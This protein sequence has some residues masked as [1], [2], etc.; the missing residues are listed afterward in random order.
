MKHRTRRLVSVLL[1]LAV[2]LLPTGA[3][4]SEL[5]TGRATTRGVANSNVVIYDIEVEG[6]VAP[7]DG[8]MPDTS[9]I[10][11]PENANYTIESVWWFNDNAE[12]TSAFQGGQEYDV[13]IYITAKQGY[14]FIDEEM[15]NASINGENVAID[16]YDSAR[17]GVLISYNFPKVP[18]TNI[19]VE[20]LEAPVPGAMPDT[21]AIIDEQAGYQIS[22]AHGISWYKHG[23]YANEVT[24][25]FKAGEFYDAIIWLAPKEGNSFAFENILQQYGNYQVNGK[26]ASLHR[27]WGSDLINIRCEFSKLDISE[28][29][30]SGIVAPEVGAMP[31]TTTFTIPNN[32]SYNIENIWWFD[33]DREQT[34]AFEANKSYEVRLFVTPKPGASFAAEDSMQ[35]S[36]N[37]N[38]VGIARYDGAEYSVL[39]A[40]KFP[41]LAS[42]QPDEENGF[43]DIF[44]TD[45]YYQPVQWAVDNKITSG[46]DP[47]HFSP[48]KP[49][50][51]AD[52]LTFLWRSMGEPEPRNVHNPFADVS[53]NAYYYKAVLWAVENNISSGISSTQFGPMQVCDRGQIVTFLWRAQ[54]KP[55]V[56]L[57]N[58]FGDVSSNQYY[59]KAVQWAVNNNIT[60]GTGAN[61]FSPAASCTRGQIV[62]FLYNA[63]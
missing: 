21:T 28:I 59:A 46:V 40:Y 58:S 5:A 56:A 16:R 7:A 15:L 49:C 31:D 47:H 26:D 3:F 44:V 60:K 48:N 6:V 61:K 63:K 14:T 55:D 10:R 42:T 38:D 45:Y 9:T 17:D 53:P 25:P 52:A 51:R 50:R 34:S 36:I 20:G 32:A 62:T 2:G 43:K 1:I 37:G 27:Y 8:E 18:I 39:I 30:V 4:A 24:T 41:A 35:A 54:G 29:D 19:K 57:S 13:R 12:H 33:G 22:Q 23:D 11:V